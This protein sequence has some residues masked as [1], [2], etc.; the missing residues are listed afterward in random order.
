M[1]KI[2]SEEIVVYPAVL[3]PEKSGYFVEVPDLE[4]AMTQGENLKDALIMAQD[5]IGLILEDTTDYPLASDIKHIDVEDSAIKTLVTVDM[6]AY[7]KNNPK[8]VRKNVT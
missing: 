3:H 6:T 2:I 4:G 5:A 1:T 8:T 7:R